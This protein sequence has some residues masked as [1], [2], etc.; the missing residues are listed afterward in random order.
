M[1]RKPSGGRRTLLAV[2][3]LAGVYLVA[4]KLGLLLA[5]VHPS[6]T[7][8]WPP[9]GL[10]LA[11][12]LVWGVHLWPGVFLGAFLAN[13]TTAGT[14][15][16]SLGIATGNT[17]EVLAGA[18]LV[19]RFA[20][21]R[22]ALARASDVFKFAGLAGL[23]STT[24][25][26]TVGVT[27]LA[28]GG[29]ADWAEFWRIWV[30]WWLG[31]AAG[32]LLVAP[33]V[34]LWAAGFRTG[35]SFARIGEAGLLLLATAVLSQVVFG[36]ALFAR[37]QAYPLAF[38]YLPLFIWAAFRFG[39]RETAAVTL[40]L[41][42]LAVVGTLQGFGPFA[43]GPHHESLL[44][45]QAFMGVMAVLTLSV[46]AEVLRRKQAE[47][48]LQKAHQDLERRVEE[49][50]E[51]LRAALAM[52]RDEVGARGRIQQ[53]L[54]EAER[55]AHLGSWY[56]DIG[57]NAVTWSEEL[58]CIFGLGPG[59]FGATYEAYLECVHP[60]DR[61]RVREAVETALRTGQPFEYHQRIVRPDGTERTLHARGVVVSDPAGRPVGMHGTCQDV[62]E[63]ARAEEE[64]RRL[65]EQVCR[66]RER[67]RAL[68]RQLLEV[69]E[70]ERRAIALELH[71]E[72]GQELTAVNLAL[73]AISKQVG[74]D[75][76][77]ARLAQT[78]S[79]VEGA[80][81]RV[82]TLSLDLRPSL[83]DELGLIAALRWH[84]DRQTLESGLALRF[85]A[86]PP[87][88]HLLPAIEIGCFRVVQ[89]AVTNVLRHAKASNL[90]VEVRQAGVMLHLHVRDDGIGFDVEQA[91]V[92]AA[93]GN[94]L[95]LLGMQE[96]IELLG[97]Q[98]EIASAPGRGT[99]I[100]MAV[101]VVATT[102]SSSGE[103]ERDAQPR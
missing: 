56:W 52:L 97:G 71:D 43:R 65:F 98:I 33:V 28:L 16:T 101:P 21:G 60:E 41:S 77:A 96:R 94:S 102:S 90:W 23:A 76:V 38:L 8:V 40:L 3:G 22:H 35:W 24:V 73:H 12:L 82:R 86:D 59:Q 53:L 85:V 50:T 99:E 14:V 20:N 49:R 87:D 34:L 37:F 32:D 75:T 92:H 48:A 10:A 74:V 7:A 64:R 72:L 93:Q 5:F 100:R 13:V 89:E 11:A 54:T 78:I 17:L 81:G 95:G 83:L 88:M 31:D 44:L 67:L 42:G 6:A 25:A 51:D 9:A 84:L 2:G 61:A 103:P 46:N 69:Q 19:N 58:Y 27:S 18:Y 68:S 79:V 36:G 57:S 62:T 63:A 45:L 66:G 29:I 15:A 55:L 4:G 1:E 80:M 39:P 47:A 26:A 91:L 70:A 30:T